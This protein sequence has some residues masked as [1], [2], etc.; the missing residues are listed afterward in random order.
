MVKTRQCIRLNFL[1]S[2]C[3][4]SALA[5]GMAAVDADAAKTTRSKTGPVDSCVKRVSLP[6]KAE[7]EKAPRRASSGSAWVDQN[8]RMPARGRSSPR[9]AIFLSP[10]G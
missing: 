8:P 10:I 5:V 4:A 7:T 9:W 1:L 2:A 3:L 6:V